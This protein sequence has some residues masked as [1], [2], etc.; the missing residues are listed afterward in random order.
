MTA[1][2]VMWRGQC[3]SCRLADAW[4]VMALML[5]AVCARAVEVLPPSRPQQVFAGGLRAVEVQLRNATTAPERADLRVLLLQLTSATAAPVGGVRAWKSLTVLPGQTVMESAA[6]EFPSVRVSTRFTARWLGV[7]NQLLGVTEIWAH[8][9]NLLDQLRLLA[10]GQPVG[11]FDERG[12]LRAALVAR[13]I[14]ITELPSAGNWTDFHGRLALVIA[15]PGT[16]QGESPLA[17]V[18][19]VRAKEGLAVVWFQTPPTIS[20]PVPPIAERMRVGRGTVL[21]APVSLLDGLADSPAAQL[22]LVRLAEQA[23]TPPTQL[24]AVTP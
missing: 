3:P 10:G 21:L 6:I 23:L 11:L 16:N 14:A 2:W 20:P 22:A 5:P 19:L 17:P 13:G 8:P 12:Q 7:D 18:A 15:K 1:A 4:L 24:L 9:D